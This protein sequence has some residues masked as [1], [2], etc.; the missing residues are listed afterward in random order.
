[1]RKNKPDCVFFVSVIQATD[2]PAPDAGRRGPRPA[3][4]PGTCKRPQ[5]PPQHDRAG[6]VRRLHSRGDRAAATRS[7]ERVLDPKRGDCVDGQ[8]S[9]ALVVQSTNAPSAATHA[10]GSLVRPLLSTNSAASTFLQLHPESGRAHHDAQPGSLAAIRRPRPPMLPPEMVPRR[11][12][13]C[14]P[15]P[16]EANPMRPR[17]ISPRICSWCI[18]APIPTARVSPTIMRPGATSPRSA[19]WRFPAP[20]P[21][22]SLARNSM[23]PSAR[24]LFPISR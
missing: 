21:R 4:R 11:T 23:T 24:R 6:S 10:P 2:P 9:A 15:K 3:T 19:C 7:P 17:T 16:S 14:F 5:D 13:G 8:I 18:T 12:P 1:M 20:S 22:K